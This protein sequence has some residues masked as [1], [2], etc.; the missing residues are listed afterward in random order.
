MKFP[1][2]LVADPGDAGTLARRVLIESDFGA[3]AAG[4]LKAASIHA[5]GT[6][7]ALPRAGA[8]VKPL[9]ASRF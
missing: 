8:L 5:S 3:S 1:K 9:A 4:C 6:G 2:L 7:L